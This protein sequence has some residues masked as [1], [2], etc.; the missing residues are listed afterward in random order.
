MKQAKNDLNY[1]FICM[2]EMDNEFKSVLS[3]FFERN[4]N[5]CNLLIDIDKRNIK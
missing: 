2:G 5:D 3:I 4:I 1:L